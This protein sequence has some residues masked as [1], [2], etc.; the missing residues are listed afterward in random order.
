M[1]NG[2]MDPEGRGLTQ[3]GRVIGMIHCILNVVV[4]LGFCVLF[5]FG[6]M[7]GKGR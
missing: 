2:E 7:G 3:A 5:A 1:D 4:F 6:G